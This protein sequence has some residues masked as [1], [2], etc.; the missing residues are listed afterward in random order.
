M[1]KSAKYKEFYLPTLVLVSQEHPS[2]SVSFLSDYFTPTGA[3][4]M[5]TTEEQILAKLTDLHEMLDMALTEL[6]HTNLRLAEIAM[7][8]PPLEI[9][10]R[11]RHGSGEDKDS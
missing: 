1:S 9:G 7:R 11:H 10:S 5:N 2:L 8:L 4:M 6:R 3:L